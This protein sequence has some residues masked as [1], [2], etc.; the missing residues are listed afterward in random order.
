[1]TY[2]VKADSEQI[3]GRNNI[4]RWAD[5]DNNEIEVSITARINWAITEAYNQINA[6]LSGCRYTVPFAVT[7]DPVIVTLSARLV[8][9]L[10]YD[11]RKLVDS[12]DF[13][14]VGWHRVIIERT[15]KQIHG[16]QLT[17]INYTRLSVAYPQAITM[18]PVEVI[19]TLE[20]LT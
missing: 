15:Y 2:S 8:G 5:L 18:D 17:L 1:M 3:F 7:I 20:T 10:L 4:L 16:G 19:E 9:V 12:P 13:D 11:N 14:E 6:R